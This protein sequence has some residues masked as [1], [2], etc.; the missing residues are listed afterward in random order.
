MRRC[1]NACTATT[2]RSNTRPNAS[3]SRWERAISS[4]SV[5]VMPG[6]ASTAPGGSIYIS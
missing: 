4:A 3:G 5:V 6:I 2:W 1:A